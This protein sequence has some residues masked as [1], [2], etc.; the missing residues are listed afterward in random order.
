MHHLNDGVYQ[1]AFSYWK[2]GVLGSF[3][4]GASG[5]LGYYLHVM[6]YAASTMTQTSW[7]LAG[8]FFLAVCILAAVAVVFVSYKPMGYGIFAA[9]G[10]AMG[11]FSVVYFS[12]AVLAGFIIAILFFAGAYA[13]GQ[14]ELGEM[15]KIR[16]FSVVRTVVPLVTMGIVVLTGT[17]LY[18]AIANQPL[19][20][21]ASLLM[22]R[23]LFQTLLIKSSGLLAPAFGTTVDFSLSVRQIT[24]QAVDTAVAQSGIPAASITP[25][26]REQLTQKYLPEFE[27][28][29]ETIIG[30]PVNL[31]E[32]VSQALYDGLVARLNA[33]E[34]N[35][36]VVTLVA[37]I[38]LLALTLLAFIPFVHIAVGAVGFLVYQ[39][40][41]AAGF[42]V[43]VYETQSKEVIVLP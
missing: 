43:I 37:I 3:V 41:L 9:A 20:D 2:G 15:L 17:A 13:R 11:L 27:A 1:N 18:G 5:V 7:I 25:A 6:V 40:L 29:F 19:A 26:M 22:P 21:A 39:L 32:P 42:G 33:L 30:G 34:G 28:K 4:V 35:T 12:Q 24:A 23:S 16:F 38:I 10:C 31:D 36:K 14:K 8:S